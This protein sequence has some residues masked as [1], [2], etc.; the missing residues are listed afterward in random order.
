M[1]LSQST[2][3]SL[4]LSPCRVISVPKGIRPLTTE[5]MFAGTVEHAVVEGV[6]LGEADHLKSISVRNILN[7]AEELLE[8]EAWTGT[9][10]D[11][12]GDPVGWATQ[13]SILTEAWWTGP[14]ATLIREMELIEAEVPR[15][16]RHPNGAL[17]YTERELVIVTGGID[18]IG[19]HP[20]RGV[21][22]VD[23]KTTGRAWYQNAGGGRIQHQLYDFLVDDEY[24]VDEWLYVIGDRSKMQWDER[25]ATVTPRSKAAALDRAWQWA[26]YLDDPDRPYLCTPS[27]GKSRGW[28]AKPAYN[29]GWCDT[30]RYLGDE[31]DQRWEGVPALG[32]DEGGNLIERHVG[33]LQ[34]V[35]EG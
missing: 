17:P 5:A 6:I 2:V 14:Y 8:D 12:V 1:L 10:A 24:E 32:V 35:K 16:K 33:Q 21:I 11:L 29:H 23:W 20:E 3:G 31:F 18:Y 19:R 28:W 13:L 26:V 7:I 30:C 9:L 4:E 27:E 22:A 15:W 34:R 25:K